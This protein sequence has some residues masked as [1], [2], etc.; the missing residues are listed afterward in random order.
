[1]EP[2]N[3]KACLNCSDMIRGRTDKKFCDDH[4]RN[5]YHN[6]SKAGLHQ[7]VR[8]LNA[9]LYRNRQ[10]LEAMMESEDELQRV[11]RERLLQEGFQFRY[12]THEYRNS[13][14]AVY[15]CCYDYGYLE[16]DARWILLVRIS[17]S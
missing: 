7:L 6:R 12:L 8:K 11:T 16:L 10:I 9:I 13:R 17:V 1:M 4:C 2:S 3:K 5:E 14:G 15:R